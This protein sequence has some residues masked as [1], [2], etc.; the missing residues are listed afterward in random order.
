MAQVKITDAPKA[1]VRAEEKLH[2]TMLEATEFTPLSEAYEKREGF[3][4][5]SVDYEMI[6]RAAH[7]FL[8]EYES[9]KKFQA[10]KKYSILPPK[11]A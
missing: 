6:A 5:V 11:R 3:K 9:F 2:E 8:D 4:V 10:T 1:L 7:K